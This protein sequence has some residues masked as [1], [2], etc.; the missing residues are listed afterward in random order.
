M[1]GVN[2]GVIGVLVSVGE[3]VTVNGSVGVL[4]GVS[5]MVGV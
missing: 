2:V 3:G 5:V 4:L 1:V